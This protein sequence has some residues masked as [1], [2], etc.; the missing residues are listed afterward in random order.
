[1][2]RARMTTAMLGDACRARGAARRRPRR[3]PRPATWRRRSVLDP[4]ETLVEP[5]ESVRL[6]DEKRDH[7]LGARAN[8]PQPIRV[9]P[10]ASAPT[11][12]APALPDRGQAA[13]GLPRARGQ[14]STPTATPWLHIRIPMRPNGRTGWVPADML[15]Q[16][17]RRAH[18]AASSIARAKRATLRKN[19]REDL[20]GAGRHR[21]GRH[22]DAA[23]QLLDPRAAQGRR[24]DL[25][26]VG[27]RHERLLEH[28]ATG[29]RAASSASTAPTS[30]GLIPG[31]RRTA[32]CACATTR[33]TSSS[34]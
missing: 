17:L 1:M 11:I 3:S 32:A 13:R 15:S 12:T 5:G 28:L 2:T 29:P 22:A 19:G 6:S 33:S 24:Q 16:L 9:A 27:V 30:P 8:D 10:M 26:A 14:A 21:Q 23:G 31:A 18:A 4:F 20:V 25:R 7:A 34:S